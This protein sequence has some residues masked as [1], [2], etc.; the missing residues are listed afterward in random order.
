MSKNKLFGIS[1]TVDR[2]AFGRCV[3]VTYSIIPSRFQ[4]KIKK[5]LS[6][7]TKLDVNESSY[8][9]LTFNY[10]KKVYGNTTN[11]T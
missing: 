4:G 2:Y 9:A 10:E 7:S 6:G 8:I 3:V 5:S 1:N 11:P